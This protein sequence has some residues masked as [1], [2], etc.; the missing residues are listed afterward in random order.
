MRSVAAQKKYVVRRRLE[1]FFA[2]VPNTPFDVHTT[3]QELAAYLAGHRVAL[4]GAT[5]DELVLAVGEALANAA[6][7]GARHGGIVTLKA[8]LTATAFEAE[9][10]DDGCGF[11]P[12][13]S[14]ELEG[15]DMA[16]GFGIYI[17]RKIMDTVEFHDGGRRV[18]LVKRF[19]QRR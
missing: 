15:R 6:E 17:M 2:S 18:V 12:P 13:E 16:R 10:A 11:V 5:T 3:R 14:F 19:A 4:H 7:H 8:S 9:V 1:A